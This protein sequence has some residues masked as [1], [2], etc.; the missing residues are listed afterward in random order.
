MNYGFIR[1]AC[2][3]PAVS[4]ANCAKNADAIIELINKA[5]KCR[6][7]VLVLPELAITGYTCG[8]LF[9]QNVLLD[10]ALYELMRIKNYVKTVT[11]VVGLPLAVGA[12]VY[13]VAAVLSDTAIKGFVPKTYIPETAEASERRYFCPYTPHQAIRFQ[14]VRVRDGD[15]VTDVPFGTDLLF[16]DTADDTVVLGVEVGSDLFA[17]LP[18][19]TMHALSGATVIANCAATVATIGKAHYRRTVLESHSARMQ[20]AYLYAESGAGE[21]TTDAVFASHNAIYE[22]GSQLAEQLPFGQLQTESQ[23]NP[24]AQSDAMLQPSDAPLIV[25]DIDTESL[26]N[27]RRR[28]TAFTRSASLCIPFGTGENGGVYGSSFATPL[29][30]YR[31]IGISFTKYDP[32]TLL[33][34][35]IA[36]TPFIPDTDSERTERACEVIAIQTAGLVKRLT[37]TNAKTAV[38][39]LSGGLDS[40][41]AL[42]ITVKAFDSLGIDKTNICAVTMPCFGT[43]NRTYNNAVSLAR[44]LGATLREIPLGR[45]V[46][47]H[48][49]DIGHDPALRDTTYENAQ[50]RERTQVLMDIA[51]D[52]GGLV[53][54]TGDL[55]ELA[56][57]WATYN[58]D[59]MSMYG[60]NAAVPKTLVRHLVAHFASVYEAEQKTDAAN[61]LRDILATPVSPELLPPKDGDISQKTEDIVGPYE[62][63]D[64]V[65]YF[66]LRKGFA[67]EKIVFLA[68]KAFAGV[69]SRSVILKWMRTFFRRFFAQQFKRSCL[70]DGP[71]IGSV[72][73][74]PRGDW[75]M[76]SDA[77]SQRW[78]SRLDS[79]E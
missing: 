17:P 66:F 12:A 76:P 14:T 38:I 62:L 60:V 39:G 3:S 68:E 20:C 24:H 54:G 57:G 72:G 40:T 8:D 53:V 49:T 1:A 19:S 45:S 41:L 23:T 50:A 15:T 7:S 29:N 46:L 51:N 59:H 42:L 28:N 75:R 71:K 26:I 18:P 67:P 4:V 22:N 70:P 55:S 2:A 11:V 37:H 30:G 61:V 33:R 58:G 63:H 25:A 31:K 56:L 10:S 65:L 47:Q 44:S 5:E 9:L 34:R 35:R 73:L 78:L 36:Q 48:F 27:D 69:Y 74:S 64:F 16:T 6:A 43:T 79:L 52:L 13:N 21:S 77:E 32:S